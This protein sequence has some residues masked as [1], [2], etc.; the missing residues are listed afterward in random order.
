MKPVRLAPIDFAILIGW[1]APM[2]LP[3]LFGMIQLQLV[4]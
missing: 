1:K 4:T 2:K 3:Y